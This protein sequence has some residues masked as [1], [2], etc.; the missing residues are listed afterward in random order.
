MDEFNNNNVCNQNQQQQ[1]HGQTE[2][3]ITNSETVTANLSPINPNFRPDS[4]H[5]LHSELFQISD[6]KELF[7]DPD[8]EQPKITI[9]S[10]RQS[11]NT[12]NYDEDYTTSTI[13]K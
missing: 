1:Y 7:V 9:S 6:V 11:T 5:D 3:A 2:N 4:M 10:S 8:T 13:Q 12:T